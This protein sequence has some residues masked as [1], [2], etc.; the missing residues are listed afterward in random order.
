MLHILIPQG[1]WANICCP[2]F[3]KIWWYHA[4]AS[5]NFVSLNV[6][7]LSWNAVRCIVPFLEN[8][9]VCY[10]NSNSYSFDKE[11]VQGKDAFHNHQ[12]KLLLVRSAEGV[13]Y[14]QDKSLHQT[15]Q[16]KINGN[17][18]QIIRML[19]LPKSQKGKNRIGTKIQA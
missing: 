2:C 5:K 14:P 8:L 3:W 16:N 18:I 7:L 15:K 19:R 4:A 11:A 13:N 12:Q 1:Q 17:Y 10:F 6:L 9:L